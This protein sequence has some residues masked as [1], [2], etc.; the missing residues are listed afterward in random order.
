MGTSLQTTPKLTF[1][2]LYD[3]E[4]SGSLISS[5]YSATNKL[6]KSQRIIPAAQS[7]STKKFLK[8]PVNTT[9]VRTPRSSSFISVNPPISNFYM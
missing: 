9:K 2:N 5:R 4:T 7:T 1:T 3:Q 8:A 6:L